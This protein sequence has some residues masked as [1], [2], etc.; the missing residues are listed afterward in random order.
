MAEVSFP[1]VGEPMTGDKWGSVTRGVGNGI[2]DQGGSP[3]WIGTSSWDN[4]TNTATMRSSTIDGQSNAIL[5]GFYHRLE[6][7]WTVE[8]P[9]VTA[10]TVYWVAIQYDP[11]RAEEEG[12]PCQLGVFTGDDLD[13]DQGKDYVVL[14]KVTRRSNEL[15]T[16]ATV[17]QFRN[18]VA[19]TI[20]VQ[21][22][23]FL[24]DPSK[25]LWGTI[26]V[27]HGEGM[28]L[29]IAKSDGSTDP[30]RWDVIVGTTSWVN[31]TLAAARGQGDP[32]LQIQ[33]EGKKRRLRGRV[34]RVGGSNN[35]DPGD[36]SPWSIATLPVGDR[37]TVITGGL[38]TVSSFSTPGFAR[39]EV[40]PTGLLTGSPSKA[41][42]WIGF[43]GLEWETN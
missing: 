21:R 2:L 29:W 35:F 19:P 36:L 39:L 10:T 31:V 18:R 24:P 28:S 15:L 37:P 26:A 22:D 4:A 16:D 6:G 17:E 34:I 1:V 32:P 12:V 20:T 11:I 7:E 25:V 42:P 9:A 3:Y 27:V 14:Y 43:E 8:L 41:S 40:D 13:F 30:V 38:G 23:E 33:R 5:N